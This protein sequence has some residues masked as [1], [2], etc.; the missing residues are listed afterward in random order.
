MAKIKNLIGERFGK[1]VVIGRTNIRTSG[2]ILRI[3]Q[4]DCGNI[5]NVRIGG[6]TSGNSTSCGCTRHEKLIKRNTSH[7]MADKRIYKIWKDMK[8][9]CYRK[10]HKRYADYGGRGIEVCKEWRD[11]FLAFYHDMGDA[12]EGKSLDRIDNDGNY[13]LGNCQ[14]ATDIEQ[15]NNKRNNRYLEFN[16]E[17]LTIAQWSRKID[18]NRKTIYGRIERG[19]SVEKTLTTPV[20]K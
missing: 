17:R 16:G 13:C 18:I 4:C 8:G 9:R 19:W 2:G 12:P 6:L 5:I 1:L 7:G 15:A 3:C 20:K 11:D 10:K 14:W